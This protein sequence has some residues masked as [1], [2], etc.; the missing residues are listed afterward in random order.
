MEYP[1]VR[2][3]ERPFTGKGFAR[4]IR[5]LGYL[6][7]VLYGRGV[8]ARP[9]VVDPKTVRDILNG[10]RARNTV[11]RLEIE[12]SSETP[13]ALIKDF[14]AHPVTR[15]LQ[16]CDFMVVNEDTELTI[17]VPLRTTGRSEGEK[18]GGTLSVGFREVTV[19]CKAG[20]VP[21]A[22]VVDVGPLKLGEVLTLSQ[23]PYPPRVRP[24]FQKDNPAILVRMPK[25]AAGGAE[26]VT[27]AAKP[28]E[29]TAPST[30]EKK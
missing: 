11:V 23:L 20:D 18:A 10:P 1:V 24:V 17:Q 25:A 2:A 27:E 16:H 30:P 4:K 8:S 6:P 13:L 26:A 7:A 29:G 19:R 12:G 5:Q 14:E 22:I 28:A 9:L 15:R 21:E 3:K